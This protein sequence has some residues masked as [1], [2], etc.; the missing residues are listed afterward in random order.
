MKPFGGNPSL[1][2]YLLDTNH[3]IEL[4]KGRQAVKDR[5]TT[6]VIQ[7]D[8]VLVSG[9][10]YYET[11]RGLLRID[12]RSQLA[13]FERFCRTHGLVLLDTESVFDLAASLAA[14][15]M[16]RGME[17]PDADVLTASSALEN[18]LVVVTNDE[19]HFGR[20]NHLRFENWL[21]AEA[22]HPH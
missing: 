9:V 20:V 5:L 19:D 16:G 8:D 2:K 14:V 1:T 18:D 11:K 15:L 6:L 3:L 17:I 12:A 7:G 4:L 13:G 21:K 10:A 22:S